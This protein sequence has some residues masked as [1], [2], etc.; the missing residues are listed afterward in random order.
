MNRRTIFVLLGLCATLGAPE[1][2]PG[3]TTAKPKL[4]ASAIQ[5]GMVETASVQIPAEFRYAFYESLVEHV[6][7]SG[8]FKKVYRAGDHAADGVPDL[9][10]LHTQVEAFKEGSQTKRELTS[11]AGATQLA[12]T[13]SVTARGGETLMA[14]KITGRVRYFGENLGVTNDIAKKITKL[15]RETF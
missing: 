9:V 13:A 2:T 11:V 15:M 14:Q 5:I 8:A 12:V 3:Q 4:A 7:D 6:R 10:T 1:I